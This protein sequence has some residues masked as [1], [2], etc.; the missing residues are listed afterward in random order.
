MPA[1]R[2]ALA[3]NYQN[4]AVFEQESGRLAEAAE[5]L[6]AR[7]ALVADD[8]EAILATAAQLGEIV[9]SP[10]SQE[11][12]PAARDAWRQAALDM[13]RHALN[14]KLITPDRLRSRSTTGGA[15]SMA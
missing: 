8:A 5:L 14:E 2:R 13:L 4:R 9:D 11:I 7:Q 10:N 6:L 15:A 3:G 1:Y 12:N